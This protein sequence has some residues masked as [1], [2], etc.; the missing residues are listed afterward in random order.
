MYPDRFASRMMGTMRKR[1]DSGDHKPDRRMEMSTAPEHGQDA[2]SVTGPSAPGVLLGTLLIL[3]TGCSNS[4]YPDANNGAEV[5]YYSS[6]SQ[7]PKHLDP[8][9]SYTVSDGIYLSLC[10]ESLMSY[11]YLERPLRLQPEL[12]LAV[13][14]PVEQRDN[15][16]KLIEI[17]YAFQIHSNVFYIDDP[18]FPGG[19]GREA[20]A[21]D[22]L[23]AFKR[24]AD[25]D[26]NCP[27]VD[28][29]GHILGFREFRNRLKARRAELAK[30]ITPKHSTSI[31]PRQLYADA[32]DLPGIR[33]TGKYSFEV[34][35]DH[36]YPQILYWL[37]MRF[38]SAI[39]WEAVAYYDG[40]EHAGEKGKRDDFDQRPVGTGPYRFEWETYNRESRIV[41]VRNK[42]WWGTRYP[43]RGAPAAFFPSE[44]G[45]PFDRDAGTWTVERAGKPVPSIDRIEW[46]REKEALPRF[47]KFLQGYYDAAAIPHESF[48]RVIENDN[49]TPEMAANGIRLVK[50]VGLD[51]FYVGFNMD[52][53]EIGA[54]AIFSDPKIE[55][56]REVELARR[57]KLRQ[58]LSLAIDMREYI[59]IFDNSLG[60]PA[61]SPLPPGLFGYEQDYQNPYAQHDIARAEQLL[62]EAGYPNGIDPSTGEPLHLTYDAGNTSTRARAI[63]NFYIDAWK[64]IGINVELAATDYNK[65][66]EKMHSGRYQIFSWGWIADYPDPENFLFLLYGPN[67]SKHGD[68]NPNHARYENAA[69]DSYFKRMETLKNEESSTWEEID[70]ATGE[71]RTV[72]MSRLEIIRVL[73]DILQEDCPW[74]PI[75]HSVDYLLYHDW[76]QH[77]KPHPIT[78]SYMRFYSINSETRAKRRHEW[79][80]PVRWPAAALVLG[81]LAFT[82]PGI[83][84]VRRERR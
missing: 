23:F 56:N 45:T 80:Q 31:D 11:A 54:P 1:G 24:L 7:P 38:V 46:Y 55:S 44:P 15:E 82:V 33:V 13:P 71:N 70:P 35:M 28:S 81:L 67:S 39:P 42:D 37:A 12:A 3:L 26:T 22:F 73:R 20:T 68:H 83:V 60:V 30:G 27:V 21:A 49:L 25:P 48:D 52:D 50:D 76:M 51:V 14:E 65:F 78:G 64:K 69:Y 41:L 17:S 58:A 53:D 9:L 74:I 72:T 16:G 79:N 2:W 4:P 8:Q 19:K 57:R 32:G 40:E 5:V 34:V 59:R 43:E 61:Q 62:R 84:M 36:Q 75:M 29:F 6:F 77:V 10:Y 63:Y 18:C 66:Q 47:N